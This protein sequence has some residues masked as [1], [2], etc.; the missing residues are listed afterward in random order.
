MKRR[1]C[2][3][4]SKSREIMPLVHVEW[5]D[6]WSRRGWESLDKLKDEIGPM[7]CKTVGYLYGEHRGMTVIVSTH[8]VDK[9][10]TDCNGLMVIPTRCITKKRRL[11]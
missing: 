11:H 1:A 4:R 8:D 6:S 7:V 3:R 9:N 10:R 2:K 5:I